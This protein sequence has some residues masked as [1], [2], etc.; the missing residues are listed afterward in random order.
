LTPRVAS[1]GRAA[2][3]RSATAG[4]LL[5]ACAGVFVVLGPMRRD[6]LP[7]LPQVAF[8]PTA[9]PAGLKHVGSSRH[10]DNDEGYLTREERFAW[11][12]APPTSTRPG[13]DPMTIATTSY[14]VDR[15]D[16]DLKGRLSGAVYDAVKIKPRA[17]RITIRGHDGVLE[18]FSPQQP[19]GAQLRLLTWIERPGVYIQIIGVGLTERQLVETATSLRE[20]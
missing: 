8:T 1:R 4:L 14:R 7:Q 5:L 6:A 20:Q 13:Q 10:G 18:V 17:R 12:A 19:Q 2:F 16:P 15:V 9:I 3:A 11:R